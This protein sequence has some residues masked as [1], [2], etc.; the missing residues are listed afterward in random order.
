M[1]ERGEREGLG[2]AGSL[3]GRLSV[4]VKTRRSRIGGSGRRARPEGW[5]QG[6]GSGLRQRVREHEAR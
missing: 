2:L 4:A 6:D 3:T 1:R 5:G